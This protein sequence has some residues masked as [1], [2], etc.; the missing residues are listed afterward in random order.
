[1][2]ACYTDRQEKQDSE[3]TEI[4]FKTPSHILALSAGVSQVVVVRG[5]WRVTSPPPRRPS[6]RPD[7]VAC[8]QRRSKVTPVGHTGAVVKTCT[9]RVGG[10]L[11]TTRGQGVRHGGVR[12]EV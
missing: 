7:R 10:G 11:G 3:E 2:R 8:V 1:M 6:L 5:E 4:V 9:L 12:G